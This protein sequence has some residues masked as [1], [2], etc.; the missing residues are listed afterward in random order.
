MGMQQENNVEF[1]LMLSPNNQV[2]FFDDGDTG[3]IRNI[4]KLWEQFLENFSNQTI[5]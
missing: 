4:N 5:F 1:R 2:K 3:K